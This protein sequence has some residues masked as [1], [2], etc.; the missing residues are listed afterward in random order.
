MIVPT[1]QTRATGARTGGGRPGGRPGRPA[2][3]GPGRCREREHDP[4]VTDVDRQPDEH[5]DTPTYRTGWRP[6]AFLAAGCLF[7][8]PPAFTGAYW[9]G[10]RSS[11]P[12]S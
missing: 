4:P 12:T 1:P 5:H 2:A 8:H 9:N 11:G 10:F 6:A 3:P 7:P